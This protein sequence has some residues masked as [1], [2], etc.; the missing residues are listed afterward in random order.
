MK[1]ISLTYSV[2]CLYKY[3]Q[4]N[5]RERSAIL[6]YLFYF[7][8]LSEYDKQ[9]TVFFFLLEHKIPRALFP[10]KEDLFLYAYTESGQP[11]FFF[12]FSILTDTNA[13]H[14]VFVCPHPFLPNT[15]YFRDVL[16]SHVKG[17]DVLYL[18]TECETSVTVF[19][20]VVK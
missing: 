15:C 2:L 4:F 14:F 19:S 20:F 17:F 12:C 11:F 18:H 16:G 7:P 13:V 6:I 9:V 3:F 8:G 10:D 1:L 5:F